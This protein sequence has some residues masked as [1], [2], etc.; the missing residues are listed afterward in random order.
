M[1][2]ETLKAMSEPPPEDTKS[3]QMLFVLIFPAVILLVCVFISFRTRCFKRPVMESLG[4][5]PPDPKATVT[6]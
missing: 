2:R 4:C 3:D 1:Q 6:D 5:N